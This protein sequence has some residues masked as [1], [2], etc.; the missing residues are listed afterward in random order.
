MF[1]PWV[2]NIPWRIIVV[3]VSALQHHESVITLCVCVCVCNESKLCMYP[4]HLEPPPKSTPPGHHRVPGWAPG[5]IYQLP[6]SYLF[7]T[8]QYIYTSILLSQFV[9]RAVSTSAFSMSVFL[10]LPCRW[11]H[12]YH[13]PGFHIYALIYYICFS[14]NYLTLYNRL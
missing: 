1:D 12:Q 9:P 7:H 13:F 11:V 2:G 4:L 3:L 6:R 5:V 10:F 8:Q 14:L